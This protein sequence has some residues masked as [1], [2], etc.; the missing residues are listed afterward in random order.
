[1]A[2][3]SRVARL[4][5]SGF[6]PEL[7]VAITG[8]TNLQLQNLLQDEEFKA[9]LEL[10][11]LGGLE[12]PATAGEQQEVEKT[13]L[14]DALAAAEMLGLRTIH[15]RLPIMEDRTLI[16]AFQAVGQ[17][18]EAE[19][20][21][22]ALTRALASSANGG[23]NTTVVINLPNIVVPELNISSRGEVVGIGERSTVPMGR[24]S[25]TALIEGELENEQLP[26]A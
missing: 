18:R 1:M 25:L 26:K 11:R 15:E 20:K 24:E 7:V 13:S 21:N 8:I 4:L 10:A 5:A 19:A 6:A 23:S 3:R 9:Q 2:M 22:E 16:H 14:Q 17:R 12:E